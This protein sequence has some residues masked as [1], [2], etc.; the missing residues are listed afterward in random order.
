MKLDRIM[1]RIQKIWFDDS[2]LFGMDCDGVVYK[3]SLLWYPRLYNATTEQ[4]NNYELGID[5]MHWR[6]IDEDISFDSFEERNNVEPTP[7]QR[8]FL[9]HKEINVAGI[10]KIIG[11]NPTL[12]RDYTYGWKKPSPKR[13]MEIQEGIRKYAQLLQQVDFSQ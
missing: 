2:H 11:V 13:V 3:Q 12:L 10:A 1:L 4:K 5:G 6:N 9:T 7:M 8:F